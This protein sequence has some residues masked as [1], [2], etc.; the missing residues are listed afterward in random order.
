[1]RNTSLDILRL[2]ACCSIV[3]LHT[4]GVPISHNMLSQMNVGRYILLAMS[5]I[6]RYGVPIFV[7]MTGVL[8]VGADKELSIRKIYAK[9]ILRLSVAGTFWMCFYGIFHL[10]YYEIPFKFLPIGNQEY[11]LWYIPM[12]II[13][14]ML[15]PV[16]RLI[17]SYPRI[18]GYTCILWISYEIVFCVMSWLN[19]PTVDLS[20][21]RFCCLALMAQGI[22]LRNWSKTTVIA[23]Y[24]VGGLGFIITCVFVLAN[25]TPDH[26]LTNSL[27]PTIL[28]GSAAILLHIKTL[29]YKVRS[30]QW[31]FF[32]TSFQRVSFGIYLVHPFVLLVVWALCSPVVTISWICV[33]VVT[34][35]VMIISYIVVSMIKK[36]PLAGKYLV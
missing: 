14:Y 20:Y 2:F 30:E 21:I 31:R 6:G 15:L 18:L 8:L 29:K 7:M 4:V 12:I 5:V 33:I 9:Y 25:N 35:L 10:W 32:L 13:V 17:A 24:V 26:L 36:I 3:L 23:I 22:M 34:L 16:L 11:H 27:S 19:M 28:A 1:M